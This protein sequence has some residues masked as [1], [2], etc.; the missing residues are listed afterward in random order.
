MYSCQIT[1]YV[2]AG[3]CDVTLIWNMLQNILTP[4]CYLPGR[5]VAAPRLRAVVAVRQ[6]ITSSAAFAVVRHAPAVRP[7]PR[8]TR[9]QAGRANRPAAARV[10]RRRCCRHDSRFALIRIRGCVVSLNI[11]NLGSCYIACT[12]AIQLDAALTIAIQ[13]INVLYSRVLY[14]TCQMHV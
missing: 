11:W 9:P 4:S 7:A 6:I 1:C 10:R 12:G 2:T 14:S 8:V 5:R 13:L 3:K